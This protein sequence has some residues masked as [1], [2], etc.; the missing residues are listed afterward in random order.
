MLPPWGIFPP[1][2]MMARSPC[3]DYYPDRHSR[4]LAIWWRLY[5]MAL[6]KGVI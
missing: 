4:L 2:H 1:Q 3:A 6:R 5:R